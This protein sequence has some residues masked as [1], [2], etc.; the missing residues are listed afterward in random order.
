MQIKGVI[1]IAIY[2]IVK[3][4]K[5]PKGKISYIYRKLRTSAPYETLV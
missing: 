1:S 5:I 2:I 4:I 3:V